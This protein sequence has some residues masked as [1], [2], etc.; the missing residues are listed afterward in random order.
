MVRGLDGIRELG[1][2]RV[3]SRVAG[4]LRVWGLVSRI[5]PTFWAL[6]FTDWASNRAVD[7]IIF[8]T[9]IWDFTKFLIAL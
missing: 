1:F 3:S 8:L 7:W 5:G 2:M 6:G 4:C 9:V